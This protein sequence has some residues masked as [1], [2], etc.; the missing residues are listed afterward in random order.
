MHQKKRF[1]ASPKSIYIGLVLILFLQSIIMYSF[2]ERK[3]GFH[4]DE[5]FTFTLSNYEN[6]FVTRSDIIN[7]WVSGEFFN[8]ALTVSSEEHFDYDMVYNNQVRD[9][10]PPLYYYVIHTVSSLF[11]GQFS[12]WI[13]IIPNMF[14][15]LLTT[16]LLF[17]AAKKLFNSN[18]LALIGTCAW[19]FSIGAM[20]SATFLRMYAM[21]TLFSVALFLCHLNAVDQLLTK[22]KLSGTTVCSLFLVT[23]L[24]ILTQYY[25]LIFCFFICGIFACCLL[26]SRQW[27]DLLKYIVA[28]FGAIAVSILYFP[29]ML[30]HIFSGYRGKEALQ[31]LADGE[32]IIDTLEQILTIISNDLFNG[33]VKELFL[34]AALVL[35]IIFARHLLGVFSVN[36]KEK[37]FV[38]RITRSQKQDNRLFCITVETLIASLLTIAIAGFVVLIA[39]IAPFKTDRYYMCIYPFLSLIAVWGIHKILLLLFN[40]PKAASVICAILI[41]TTTVFSYKEQTPSYLYSTY[42]T[43]EVLQDYAGYNAVV[44]NGATYDSAPHQWLPEF[45]NYNEIY[46][47]AKN[48]DFSCLENAVETLDLTEGFLLYM[49]SITAPEEELFSTI[50]EYVPIESYTLL[51]SVG[52]RVYFCTLEG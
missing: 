50:Q 36:Y 21:L 13:G 6:G 12:K 47:G 48:G 22:K 45:R 18:T 51:T 17:F 31:N 30:T 38:I 20:D 40:R 25:F 29:A 42:T 1:P 27:K 9:V 8:K 23:L 4:L 26:L 15:C 44:L 7:E 34:L 14:F 32:N 10:H 3:E 39:K 43:R 2:A 41:I 28:E 35:L 16:I 37:T 5:I 52:C 46:W 33:Y 24:G 19:A 11:E 49:H